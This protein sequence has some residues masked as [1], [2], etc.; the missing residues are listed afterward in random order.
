MAALGRRRAVPDLLRHAAVPPA[1]PHRQRHEPHRLRRAA[2][3]L[4]RAVPPVGF[5]RA[6]PAARALGQDLDRARRRRAL[7]P[8]L[9]A[10]GQGQPRRRP[11]HEDVPHRR[12]GGE[13]RARPRP[14]GPRRDPL[15]PRGD[16]AAPRRA[17]PAGRAR[18][19]GRSPPAVAVPV[20][21]HRPR[22][23]RRRV[24]LAL[25]PHR[26]P[27]H[28][29]RS[30]RSLSG[31]GPLPGGRIF[32]GSCRVRE[33]LDDPAQPTLRYL[34]EA[35]DREPRRC[36]RRRKSQWTTLAHAMHNGPVAAGVESA[37]GRGV[38]RAVPRVPGQRRGDVQRRGRRA[39]D[40][41]PRHRPAEEPGR[42]VRDAVQ[43]RRLRS[44]CR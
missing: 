1:G 39:A 18:P 12:A 24:H 13:G 11:K 32:L 7:G 25:R 2:G 19:A 33:P 8:P 30:T 41:P 22:A 44:P 17:P 15:Q 3:V 27:Q 31:A 28:P 20:Q 35:A 34:P 29:A 6:E 40:T 14:R 37:G 5:G 43:P 16:S 10:G 21:H 23:A 9:A 26:R 42:V 4:R 38:R 36:D